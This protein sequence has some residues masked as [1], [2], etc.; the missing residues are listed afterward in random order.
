L[1][2]P[3][4]GPEASCGVVHAKYPFGESVNSLCH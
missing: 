3:D 4:S 2:A 1:A